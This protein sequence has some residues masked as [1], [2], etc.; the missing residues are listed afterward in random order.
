MQEGEGPKLA[1]IFGRLGVGNP[2]LRRFVLRD[3]AQHLLDSAEIA[4]GPRLSQS[5]RAGLAAL[6][7]HGRDSG[8]SARDQ[9]LSLAGLRL[10]ALI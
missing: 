10:R 1:I 7:A 4:A 6:P 3:P 9:S 2:A 5:A 8:L